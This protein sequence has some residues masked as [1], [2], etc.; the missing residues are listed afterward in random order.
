MKHV[1]SDTA[2]VIY[3][4][5]F[6]QEF[7]I[8]QIPDE[9]DI[10]RWIDI[11]AHTNITTAFD[12]FRDDLSGAHFSMAENNSGGNIFQHIKR[13][14]LNLAIDVPRSYIEMIYDVAI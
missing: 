2:Y 11:Q 13:L 7:I 9:E 14:N 3:H 8:R 12:S 4:E 5:D 10:T 6:R 1:I